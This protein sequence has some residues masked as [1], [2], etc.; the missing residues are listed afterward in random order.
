MKKVIK[1][2]ESDLV[3]IVKKI[4]SETTDKENTINYLLDKINRYG[5]DSLTDDELDMLKDPDSI[6]Y[7]IEDEGSENVHKV[8]KILQE[9]KLI[10]PMFVNFYDDYFDLYN[11][12]GGDFEY[13]SQY[14]GFL[15]IEVED[16][17]EE[18]DD[19]DYLLSVNFED[20]FDVEFE[21]DPY[22]D[23]GE[24]L[25]SRDEIINYME[26]KWLPKLKR[27]RIGLYVADD[28]DF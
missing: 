4:I 8:V 23:D 16:V 2:N 27:K 17:S 15:R 9:L 18:E 10:N 26:K 24:S 12:E 3:K 28:F 7:S 11:M 14:D 13:F 20:D 19:F 5:K 25:L 6:E 1:L 22:A 21:G